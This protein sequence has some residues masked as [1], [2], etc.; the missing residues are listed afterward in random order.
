MSNLYDKFHKLGNHHNNI[1]VILGYLKE[2]LK[3]EFPG[4]KGEELREKIKTLSG[5]LDKIDKNVVDADQIISVI[6]PFIYK[7][8]DKKKEI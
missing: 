4:L 5:D 7:H 3:V 6:E 1:R 8:I 2:V